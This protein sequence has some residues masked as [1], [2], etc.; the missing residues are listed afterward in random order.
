[1]R[2]FFVTKNTGPSWSSDP[3]YIKAA[4]STEQGAIDFVANLDGN[5]IKY[6]RDLERAD[7]PVVPNAEVIHYY[8]ADGWWVQIEVV[9]LDED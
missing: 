2:V 5:W 8:G 6:K 9:N 1:M 4:K 3:T 7:P